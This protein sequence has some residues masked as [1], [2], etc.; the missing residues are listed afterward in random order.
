MAAGVIVALLLD[1]LCWEWEIQ[2]S[3]PM[4]HCTR[5]GDRSLGISEE[6]DN[7]ATNELAIR[8]LANHRLIAEG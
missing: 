8:Y 1:Y 6:L 5:R 4:A 7:R 3:A 2:L